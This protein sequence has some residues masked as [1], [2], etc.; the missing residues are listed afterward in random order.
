MGDFSLLPPITVSVTP[1]SR[2]FKTMSKSKILLQFDT[3]SHSCAFD[4]VVAVD[5]GVDQLF[6]YGDITLDDVQRLVYGAIFTRGVEDLHNT[7]IFVGGSDV[8]KGEAIVENI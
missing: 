2:D 4:G 8:A 6:Q 5:S 1:H 7:A 3:D